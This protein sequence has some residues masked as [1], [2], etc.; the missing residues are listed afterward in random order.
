MHWW[1]NSKQYDEGGE[2]RF[3][4]LGLRYGENGIFTDESDDSV[5]PPP[6][7][8]TMQLWISYMLS[9]TRFGQIMKN[10][11]KDINPRMIELLLQRK[12]DFEKLNINIQ[13]F[14][15]RTNI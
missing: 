3:T 4:C 13:D 10:E 6:A 5:L 2:L 14:P 7:D 15:S 11:E 1:S 9:N 12:S 8:A